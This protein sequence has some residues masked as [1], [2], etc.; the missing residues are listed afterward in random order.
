MK[1]SSNYHLSSSNQTNIIHNKPTITAIAIGNQ[2]WYDGPSTLDNNQTMFKSTTMQQNEDIV[3]IEIVSNTQIHVVTLNDTTNIITLWCKLLPN[4]EQQ[5]NSNDII[6]QCSL[7]ETYHPRT[8]TSPH[9]QWLILSHNQI[10]LH[11]LTETYIWTANSTTKPIQKKHTGQIIWCNHEVIATTINDSRKLTWTTYNDDADSKNITIPWWTT[12]CYPENMTRIDFSSDFSCSVLAI[13]SETSTNIQFWQLQS[14]DHNNELFTC[15]N[16]FNLSSTTTYGR[17]I[18]SLILLCDGIGIGTLEGIFSFHCSSS[19]NNNNGELNINKT[20]TSTILSRRYIPNTSHLTISY[21]VF[22]EQDN[23]DDDTFCVVFWNG[24]NIFKRQNLIPTKIA[25]N[26]NIGISHLSNALSSRLTMEDAYISK[27][28]HELESKL[29]LVDMVEKLTQAEAKLDI[30]GMDSFVWKP[31]E[32]VPV[33]V[34]TTTTN[35]N[36]SNN[37]NSN[38]KKV[39]STTSTKRPRMSVPKSSIT[40]TIVGLW[41]NA[42]TNHIIVQ[43]EIHTNITSI[44]DVQ[45]LTIINSSNNNHTSTIST[46]NISMIQQGTSKI[47]QNIIHF[48]NIGGNNNNTNLTWLLNH[49]PIMIN[50][51]CLWK[52][53]TNRFCSQF[54][55]SIPLLNSIITSNNSTNST[56]YWKPWIGNNNNNNSD[57]GWW[58]MN[59]LN[60]TTTVDNN[61]NNPQSILLSQLGITKIVSTNIEIPITNNNNIPSSTI[62]IQPILLNNNNSGYQYQ[63]LAMNS[64][65]LDLF[66]GLQKIQ[67]VHNNNNNNT[68]NHPITTS[69]EMTINDT[70]EQ[71]SLLTSILNTIITLIEDENTMMN[72]SV[73]L[74]VLKLLGVLLGR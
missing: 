50:L 19:S 54:I 73:D 52:S 59:L 48:S 33:V 66:I 55:E 47:V 40:F 23:D 39:I 26:N 53:P 63:I 25:E 12:T 1:S 64:M 8:D 27:L 28:K 74:A 45:L 20:T 65:C 30:S 70:N 32:L 24:G 16:Q 14:E 5:W 49:T 46:T 6:L 72:T 38:V 60:T 58:Q 69:L 61:N 4:H 18:N 3:A 7:P 11:T 35:N 62:M 68:T 42:L 51:Y 57:S 29:A 41:F 34:A 36:N 9:N 71:K 15:Y 2:I 22:L 56:K 31:H 43:V 17:E 13:C 37:N 10:C 44:Y 67:N 21:L